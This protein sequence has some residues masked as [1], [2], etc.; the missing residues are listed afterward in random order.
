MKR[1]L[2]LI[3][4]AVGAIAATNAGLFLFAQRS[5]QHELDSTAATLAKRVAS[6]QGR[7]RAL[8]DDAHRRWLAQQPQTNP[9]DDAF[10]A[11]LRHLADSVPY[12]KGISLLQGATLACTSLPDVAQE[13]V[14]RMLGRLLVGDNYLPASAL[15]FNSPGLVQYYPYADGFNVLSVLQA[16]Y[17]LDLLGTQDPARYRQVVLRVKSTYLRSDRQVGPHLPVL[18]HEWGSAAVPGGAQV[19]VEASGTLWWQYV[20]DSVVTW[21]LIA[22]G[23]LW[24]LLGLCRRLTSNERAF[25]RVLRKAVA[26]RVIVPYYQPLF[27]LPGQG[28]SGVE[29]LAR[30]PLPD[31]RFVPP[32]VFIARAE[33]SGVIG[34]LTRLLIGR[35]IDDLPALRLPPGT[36]LA[37]NLPPELLAD[38]ALFA[39]IEHWG[40]TLQAHRLQPVIEV[41]ERSFV[42]IAQTDKINDVFGRLRDHGIEVALDDFGAEYSSLGYLH[43]FRFDYVKIDGLFLDGIGKRREVERVLDGVL[44]IASSLELKVVVEKVETP[45]QLAYL[46][47]RKVGAAQGY[48][49]GRP[50]SIDV[51][52]TEAGGCARHRGGCD[53]SVAEC[54]Q[55]RAINE[56]S[57][58]CPR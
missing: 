50:V 55:E 33:K 34:D 16:E 27:D 17:F 30:W 20:R 54:E 52:R 53:H 7:A 56:A 6:V 47:D 13:Q 51:W 29:I 38:E 1:R 12:V 46:N 2:L 36:R 10:T 28:L 49:F 57:F 42:T 9:C 15:N 22:A 23:V 58:P 21:N 41:T 35:V 24:M 8:A 37:L 48:Y 39:Y 5:V 14:D 43:R 11:S 4:A 44:N 40:H 31:G 32:D 25:D 3:L 26:G 19:Y 18:A 45:V